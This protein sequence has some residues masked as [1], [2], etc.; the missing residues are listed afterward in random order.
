M[1]AV[2][3]MFKTVSTDCNLDCQYCYYRESLEGTRVR[4]RIAPEMLETFMAQ[5]MD[6][7]SDAKVA[8]ISWQGGEPTLAGLKFFEQVVALEA[9][10]AKP[11]TTI[12]NALQTNGV[13]LN[14]AWGE[15]FKTYNFLVG[16]SLDGPEE[17]HNSRRAY[18]SGRG[19]FDHVMR[20]IEVLRR[21]GVAFNILCVLGPHNVERPKELLSFYRQQG[22]SHVQF[23]PEMDFQAM[24]TDKPAHFQITPAQYG[25]FLREAFDEWYEDGRPTISVRTFDN[26]LQNYVGVATDLCVHSDRCDAGIVVEYNG[27][28]Y[29]CDFYIHPDWKL[30]NVLVAPLREILKNPKR[31]AFVL[32]KHQ[33]LPDDCQ[34][35]E[36]L[37]VCKTGCPRNRLSTD[38]GQTPDYFCA[39]YKEFF[40]HADA[41]L[42]RVKERVQQKQKY[43]NVLQ[44]APRQVQ[45]LGPNDACP[46]GS[47][48]KLKKCCQ[49]PAEERSYLFRAGEGGRG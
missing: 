15:F 23:I 43:L 26:F 41:R 5:Y 31:L 49:N 28:V 11:G 32:Q 36:W 1:P 8:S 17:I 19:S 18:K 46:C 4:R 40:S 44:V 20:G 27:D 22:F 30:G 10:Y 14:D 34:R 21:H 24:E 33:P 48:K 25:A 37:R 35:C 13:L 12:S 47:G 7:V 16:V 9:H 2:G 29:P 6:Y 42:S 3:V 39:S 38:D 45:R